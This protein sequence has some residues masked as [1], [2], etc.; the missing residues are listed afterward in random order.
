VSFREH[1][2]VLRWAARPIIAAVISAAALGALATALLPRSYESSALLY[3]GPLLAEREVEYDGLLAA[4]LVTRTYARLAVTRPLLESAAGTLPFELT[5]DEIASRVSADIPVEGN[6]LVITARGGTPSEAAAIANAVADQI[7]ERAP[8][9]DDE[10]LASLLGRLETLDL[11]IAAI[12]EE[13]DELLAVAN[14]TP[15]QT[16]QLESLADRLL[17][18]KASRDAMSNELAAAAPNAVT[19]VEPAQAPG[20]PSSPRRLYVVGMVVVVV[21]TLTLLIAYGRYPVRRSRMPPSR[22]RG[23]QSI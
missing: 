4:Q 12:Q 9:P 20:E 11:T 21:L 1:L 8:D 5:T 2:N 10:E 7:M 6:L 22:S 18:F 3:V 15:A 14:R 23:Q 13:L 17:S 19:L 16:A